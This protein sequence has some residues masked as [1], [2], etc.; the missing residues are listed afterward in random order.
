[1]SEDPDTSPQTLATPELP[2]EQWP[3]WAS[4]LRSQVTGTITFDVSTLPDVLLAGR[5]HKLPLELVKA[6]ARALIAIGP[7]AVTG[8][9]K[10]K[11]HSVFAPRRQKL[12][13]AIVAMRDAL[14][15]S[16]ARVFSEALFSAW[17][18]RKYDPRALWCAWGWII[19]GDDWS[20]YRLYELVERFSAEG[21]SSYAKAMN[22]VEALKALDTPMAT[23]TVAMFARA[24]RFPR[25]QRATA[26]FLDELAERA[27]MTTLELEDARVPD[28]G[29]DARGHRVLDYGPRSFTVSVGEDLTPILLDSSGGR[30]L[31]PPRK[32]ESDDALKVK[33]AR[34]EWELLSRGLRHVLLAQSD[35]LEQ[36]ML[37]GWR[38]DPAKWDANV[39]RHPLMC[40]FARALL[41]GVYDADHDD[42]APPKSLFRVAEDLTLADAQ[43]DEIPPPTDGVVGVVHP[44]DLS[45]E[46]VSRWSQIFTDYQIAT[47]FEQLSRALYTPEEAERARDSV[48]RLADRAIDP[49]LFREHIQ[50]NG[51]KRG[52]ADYSSWRT[53]Y[54]I[55]FPWLGQ[56]AVWHLDPGLQ[57]GDH[58]GD[59]PQRIHQVTFHALDRFDRHHEYSPRLTVSGVHPIVFSEALRHAHQLIDRSTK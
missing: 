25:M 26:T 53:E 54:Y 50:H 16:S 44:R 13:R 12:T 45:P 6:F 3:E 55:D 10:G 9:R 22:L 27:G 1:M 36:L 52:V 47:P 51:F 42:A 5:T 40:H 31:E 59:Q 38:W 37:Q 39:R 56:R 14:D 57:A 7:P 32:K 19:L 24:E 30:W 58:S 28:L 23:M 18:I 33:L 34:E 4:V 2:E 49:A 11:H 48:T 8:S 15:V 35:R 41:W 46:L 43:D 20:T 21:G 17:Q 29:L